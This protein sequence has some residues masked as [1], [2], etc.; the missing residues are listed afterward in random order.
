MRASR[1]ADS[2][3]Y[4]QQHEGESLVNF[5]VDKPGLSFP[6]W[7][8][9][10]R[11]VL[12]VRNSVPCCFNDKRSFQAGQCLHDWALLC[13]WRGTS[14]P[15]GNWFI[16]PIVSAQGWSRLGWVYASIHAPQESR[17]N[18]VSGGWGTQPLHL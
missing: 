16:F 11:K 13:H 17:Q 7:R 1:L 12:G 10:W 8:R 9:G 14:N 15:L 6:Y 4:C 5:T 3:H 18:S 2:P